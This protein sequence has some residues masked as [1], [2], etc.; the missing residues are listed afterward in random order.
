MLV[1]VQQVCAYVC[2]MNIFRNTYALHGC[3]GSDH[4]SAECEA[5]WTKPM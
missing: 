1:W 2:N 3:P 4:N 5:L